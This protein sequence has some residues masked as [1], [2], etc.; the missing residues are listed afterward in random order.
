MDFCLQSVIIRS[1]K[2]PDDGCQLV[3][4]HVAVNRFI[5]LMLRVTDLVHVQGPAEIPDDFAKQL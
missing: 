5:N 3:P 4:K 2:R 1:Y